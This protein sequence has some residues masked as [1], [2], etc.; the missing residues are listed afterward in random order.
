VVC[1]AA[2]VAATIMSHILTNRMPSSLRSVDVFYDHEAP[3]DG[4]PAATRDGPDPHH[5]SHCVQSVC[6]CYAIERWL[7]MG[8]IQPAGFGSSKNQTWLIVARHG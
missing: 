3:A 2:G 5:L 1:A 7:K 4:V 8:S 6:G